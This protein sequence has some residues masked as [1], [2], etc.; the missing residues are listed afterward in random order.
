MTNEKTPAVLTHVLGILTLFVGPLIMYFAYRK[1]ASPWLRE[2]LDES[3][4][5]H[6]LVP[7]VI[8]VLGVAAVF[9][10]GPASQ[11]S[12]FL[13]VAAIVLFA[14]MVVFSIIAVVKAAR[15]KSYHFPLDIKLI[16]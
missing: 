2:H 9:L 15:G 8:V 11:V 14:L 3:V 7:V 10:S 6:I 1:N 13:M 16:R 4:N 12:F 5:Y